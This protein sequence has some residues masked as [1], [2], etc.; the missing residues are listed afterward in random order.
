MYK[1][2]QIGIIGAGSVFTPELIELILEKE[3]DVSKIVFMDI[4]SERLEILASLAKRQIENSAMNIDIETSESYKDAIIDSDFIL[5]QPR[6]GK[7]HMRIEDE[8]LAHKYRI[9]YVETVSVPGLGAFLRTVPVYDEIADLIKEHASDARIMNF[10]NPAGPLTTYLH[11]IGLTNTVGVCNVPVSYVSSVAEIFDVPEESVSM[12]WKGVNHFAAADEVLI[13]GKDVLP[14]LAEKAALGEYYFPFSLQVLK[15]T[16]LGLSPYFQWYLHSDER[17]EELLDKEKSRGEE[18]KEL[19]KEL[20]NIYSQPETIEMPELLKKRGG[21]KYS[22]VVANLIESFQ[23]NNHHVHYINVPNNGTLASL[24]DETIIEV[25]AIVQNGEIF[26]LQAGDLPKFIK[27]FVSNMATVYD[28]WISAV[29]NKDGAS[30]RKALMLDSVFPDA[31]HSDNLLKELFEINKDY[32]D[33]FYT[34]S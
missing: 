15:D 31:K 16:R 10:A 6:V 19:E 22:E 12:N 7:G 13:D 21:F 8:K 5:L 17:I 4:D 18:V 26:P 33:N 29:L 28:Y 9:P 23:T 27:S 14:E 3:L 30:L 2:V 11:R 20:L 24:S 1:N 34:G 25:P 32:I